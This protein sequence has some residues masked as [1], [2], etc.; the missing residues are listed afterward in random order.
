[1]MD[2]PQGPKGFTGLESSEASLKEQAQSAVGAAEPT[3]EKVEHKARQWKEQAREKMKSTGAE[4]TSKAAHDL[5]ATAQALRQTGQRLREENKDS[6]SRYADKAAE[7]T[8]RLSQYLRDKDFGQLMSDAE[9]FIRSRP[10][11]TV[12]G[13]LV[14]GVL[15]ARFLKASSEKSENL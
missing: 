14:A 15:L 5:D 12:G 2:K 1:M 8:D 6:L 10:L 11:L 13:A 4:R 3:R 7:Q 9:D